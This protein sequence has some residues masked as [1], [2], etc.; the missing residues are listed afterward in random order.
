MNG[1]YPNVSMNP[2]TIPPFPQRTTANVPEMGQFVPMIGI[3]PAYIEQQH[4]DG[5]TMVIEDFNQLRNEE[6]FHNRIREYNE[7]DFFKKNFV[8]KE[9][10]SGNKQTN[11]IQ[12]ARGYM[13]T[14]TTTD[15]QYTHVHYN[16]NF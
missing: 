15:T 14:N 12:F 4:Y 16:G 9:R 7:V 3:I 13:L 11:E 5:I 8:V 6:S 2:G 10:F 1:T